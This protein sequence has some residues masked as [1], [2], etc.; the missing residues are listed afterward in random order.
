M[1]TT[2]HHHQRHQR[3]GSF[4]TSSILI[5]D[6]ICVCQDSIED[7][8]LQTGICN[9][10]PCMRAHQRWCETNGEIRSR[11]AVLAVVLLNAVE[12][13]NQ[14]SER[15]IV[16]IG[17]LIDDRVNSVATYGSV[18]EASSIYEVVVRATRQER[19]REL[20]EELFEKTGYTVYIVIER[21]WV[22]EVDNLGVCKIVR[23]CLS[24]QSWIHVPWS[25]RA[26]ICWTWLAVPLTR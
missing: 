5:E 1:N 19:I 13:Q 11:H 15:G 6:L 22:A 26:L 12:M 16:G 2:S 21:C 7:P 25:K 9:L 8:R 3:L 10:W 4:L 20:A 18:I 17:E 24:R 23:W 14:S